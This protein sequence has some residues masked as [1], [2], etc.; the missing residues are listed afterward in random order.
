[1]VRLDE[2]WAV[3]SQLECA[4][5]APFATPAKVVNTVRDLTSPENPEPR[6]LHAYLLRH[7]QGVAEFHGRIVPLHGRLF[8]LD[9]PPVPSG[10]PVS[11]LL[12][13]DAHAAL[14]VPP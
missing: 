4:I 8:A 1:M 10:V 14:R 6:G 13:S 3:M 7:L 9:A 5:A 12:A 11:V 2:C